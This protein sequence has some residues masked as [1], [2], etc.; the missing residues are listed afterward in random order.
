M[1]E[2][3]EKATEKVREFFKTRE[4]VEPLRVFIAGMGC[5]GVQLGF[6]LDEANENDETFELDGHTYLVEKQLL[7]QAKPIKVDYITTAEGEGFIIS[8]SMK[9][10]TS[11]GGGCCGC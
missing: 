3:T 2:V 9:P 4:K 7:E 8:S 11:C 1:F 6:A 10:S 5:S